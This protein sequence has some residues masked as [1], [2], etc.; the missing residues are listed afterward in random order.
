MNAILSKWRCRWSTPLHA[1]RT[2]SGEPFSSPW[3]HF[4][5]RMWARGYGLPAQRKPF[6][7]ERWSG[8]MK[9]RPA[10]RQRSPVALFH[11]SPRN[12]RPPSEVVLP[13]NLNATAFDGPA[14]FLAGA[15]PPGSQWHTLR[16][17]QAQP[18]TPHS[19]EGPPSTPQ[20]STVM[21]VSSSSN[22]AQGWGL[23]SRFY[24]V[25]ERPMYIPNR[26][27]GPRLRQRLQPKLIKNPT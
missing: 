23:G 3:R 8:S 19:S 6:A 13:M 26:S 20:S 24:S 22:Q 25:P 14:R 4:P 10:Q 11:K 21:L 5:E 1:V 7:L 2:A 12:T 15:I 18:E 27:T 17:M 16:S 9:S